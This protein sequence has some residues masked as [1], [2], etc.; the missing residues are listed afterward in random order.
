M[1]VLS[2]SYCYPNARRRE[3]GIFVQQRL[4][5][6]SRLVDVE[7]VSPVGLCWPARRRAGLAHEETLAGLKVHRPGFFYTP[8]L[9]KSHDA[10][11]YATGIKHWLRRHVASYQPDV[12]D[13]H[14]IW[15]DGSA[16]ATLARELGVPYVITLR[17]KIFECTQPRAQE[18]CTY[19]LKHAAAI[20]SVSRQMAEVARD[21]GANSERIHVITNGVNK[22]LFYPRDRLACR[23]KLNLPTDGALIV[24][25]A[26]LKPSK[27]VG[28][29][30]EAMPTVGRNVR[31]VI[32]GA[33]AMSGYAKT[34]EQRIRQLH[35]DQRVILTGAQPFE[36]I[37]LFLCA[38][39][40][41]VLASHR[42]GCP[43]VVLESLSCGTP[44]VASDVGAVRDIL[45]NHTDGIIFPHGNVEK[46][47]AAISRTLNRSWSPSELHNAPSVVSWSNNAQQVYEVLTSCVD[48]SLTPQPRELS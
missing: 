20:I 22:N 32:V 16:V 8:G 40:V 30:V 12:L 31:L 17:G 43:N 47:S 7:V 10:W 9:F 23:R 48:S 19:A 13:V 38:G 14:F 18:Q 6:L 1:K 11:F 3:W 39:D 46:L 45:R 34:L 36:N 26:H 25:V 35:I 28:D 15:P 29:L 42:E 33:E 24:A 5:A 4:K 2:F 41:C 37:P 27:G 21:W 44:V